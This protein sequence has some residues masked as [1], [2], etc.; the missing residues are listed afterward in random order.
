MQFVSLSACQSTGALL[1]KC[2]PGDTDAF[3]AIS[4]LLNLGQQTN[5]QTKKTITVG[6]VCTPPICSFPPSLL[7][8]ETQGHSRRHTPRYISYS[9]PSGGIKHLMSLATVASP[10]FPISPFELLILSASQCKALS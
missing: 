1:Q 7:N 3:C 8:Q 6:T 5:K 10:V 2:S 9:A 4:G